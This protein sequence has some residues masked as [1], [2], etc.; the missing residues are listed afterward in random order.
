MGAPAQSDDESD[1]RAL[2]RGDSLAL[3]RLMARREMPLRGFLYRHTLNEQDALD[4]A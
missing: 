3:N 1:I 2:Q 4:L